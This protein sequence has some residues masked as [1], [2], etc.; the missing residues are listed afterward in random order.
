MIQQLF[1]VSLLFVSYFIVVDMHY[2]CQFSMTTLELP[3]FY[4]GR[5]LSPTYV[6]SNLRADD[7]C[8]NWVYAMSFTLL[9]SPDN[10]NTQVLFMFTLWP[11]ST[12]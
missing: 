12:S 2:S 10:I 11:A 7:A 4:F 3:S 6:I 5:W 1:C 8:D 9:F